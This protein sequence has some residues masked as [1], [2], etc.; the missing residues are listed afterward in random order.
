M[1]KIEYKSIHE[2]N[3]LQKLVFQK[4]K[5]TNIRKPLSMKQQIKLD[6]LNAKIEELRPDIEEYIST[7]PADVRRIMIFRYIQGLYWFQVGF[8][9]EK[10]EDVV[11]KRVQRAL[12]RRKEMVDRENHER[13]E[14]YNELRYGRRY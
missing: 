1:R 7:F 12:A 11:K 10:S 14:E 6:E 9:V 2:L 5:L 13:V 4:K 8:Q 3:E